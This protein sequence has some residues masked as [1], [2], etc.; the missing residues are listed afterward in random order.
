MIMNQWILQ[1][2]IMKQR[3]KKTSLKYIKKYIKC[4]KTSNI[5]INKKLT[6]N[7]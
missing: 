2:N 7:E 5:S 1:K 6:I 4:N 3:K